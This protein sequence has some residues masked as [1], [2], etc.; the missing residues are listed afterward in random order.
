MRYWIGKLPTT[1][2]SVPQSAEVTTLSLKPT[3][4]DWRASE[5]PSKASQLEVQ[6]PLP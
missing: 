3:P 4:S 6:R 1:T 5:P 2:R